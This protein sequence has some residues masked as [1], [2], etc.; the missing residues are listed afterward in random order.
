MKLSEIAPKVGAQLKNCTED[1]E[2]DG[3]AQLE[4]AHV[5]EIAYV[6]N[7]KFAAAARTT[8]ASAL[9][10]P[11]GFAPLSVPTLRCDYPFLILTRVLELLYRPPLYELGVHSTAVIH[12]S[13]KIGLRASIGAY[14]VIDR[15]VE[16]GDDAVL[17]PHVVIYRGVRIGKNFF[18]HAHAVVREYCRLGDDVVLQNGAVIGADGFG[19]A[20][21]RKNRQEK[22]KK[23]LHSGRAVLGDGV[24]VQTNACVQRAIAGETRIGREVKIGD[25][26]VIGHGVS[27]DDYSMLSPQ[28]GV[29]GEVCIGKHVSLL[30][31]A[32]VVPYCKIGDGATI[33]VQ[34]GVVKDVEAGHVVSGFPAVENRRWL[35]SVT[36]F[37][38]LPE[39][40]LPLHVPSPRAARKKR[41]LAP[42]QRRCR[43]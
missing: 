7:P 16:I 42:M 13:A 4:E 22:L 25:L 21:E 24:E 33:T 38:R 28:V 34:S 26:T 5:G 19:F 41:A 36:L 11:N 2:I 23:T 40:T 35:R 37:K 43:Q 30:G 32:G 20:R 17:L 6:E 15:D 9:I 12:Q 10:V 8:R 18:A 14:V 31:Q 1:V 39:L 29:A 27:V 3:V